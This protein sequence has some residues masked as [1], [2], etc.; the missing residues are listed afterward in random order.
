MTKHIA[1]IL[2][3]CRMFGSIFLLFLPAFSPG[4]YAAY[5]LCGLSD[6]VDGTV[7]RKTNSASKLGSQLDSIADTIFVAASLFKWLLA[8]RTP[9]WLWIWGGMIAVIKIGNIIWGFVSR[10]RFISLHTTMNKVT[11]LLLFLL[12]LTLSFVELKC[13]SVAVCAAATFAAIQE[14]FY[15]ARECR[16]E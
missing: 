15:I 4:F 5:I 6:M 3:G 7:A 8:I 12:P 16:S 11:G 9:Q 1:N 14:G 13:S 10:N 2:T